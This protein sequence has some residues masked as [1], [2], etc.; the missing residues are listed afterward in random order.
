MDK[1]PVSGYVTPTIVSAFVVPNQTSMNQF[2][3]FRAQKCW[4][5]LRKS[6]DRDERVQLCKPCV[7]LFSF[8]RLF[9]DSR[10]YFMTVYRKCTK[11]F[12]FESAKLKDL[13][14]FP[15]ARYLDFL[16][17]CWLNKV[18]FYIHVSLCFSPPIHPLLSTSNSLLPSLAP[19][20]LSLCS[21]SWHWR[22]RCH[23]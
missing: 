15:W 2:N 23:A 19:F 1:I 11:V 16:L 4:T 17:T 6:S 18:P 10:K 13:H 9:L 8:R 22:I 12:A 20:C 14:L 3:K 5:S 21:R 7:R